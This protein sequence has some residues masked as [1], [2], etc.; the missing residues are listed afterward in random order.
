MSSYLGGGRGGATG[1]RPSQEDFMMQEIMM[2]MMMGV[3]KTC[4]KECV[5]SFN[6]QTLNANEQNCIKKCAGRQ[7][8]AF[9]SMNQ[10]QGTL[11]QKAGGMGG[12]F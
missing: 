7:A 8:D 4:F 12:G 1:G 11:Q 5:S 10:I 9:Q 2:K 3:T 6:D